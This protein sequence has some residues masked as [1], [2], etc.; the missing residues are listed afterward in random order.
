MKNRPLGILNFY[1]D[2]KMK[3]EV[4]NLHDKGFFFVTRLI[5]RYLFGGDKT[6]TDNFKYFHKLRMTGKV[7]LIPADCSKQHEETNEELV[8]HI[9]NKNLKAILEYNYSNYENRVVE[10]LKQVELF[11][12]N[13]AKKTHSYYYS[14]EEKLRDKYS[15]LEG[16]R[17]FSD[18]I[19]DVTLKR[20]DGLDGTYIDN[21]YR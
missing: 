4:L 13:F 2:N 20:T 18:Q 5:R 12:R 21:G 14:E 15:N 9:L 17:D 10:L 7:Y 8:L 16:N 1:Y 19:Y 6:P 11:N 3:N